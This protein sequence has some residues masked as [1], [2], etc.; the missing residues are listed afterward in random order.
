MPVARQFRVTIPSLSSAPTRLM[1]TFRR[2][3]A[4]LIATALLPTIG[5]ADE[6][7]ATTESES[8]WVTS[9]AALGE[10]GTPPATESESPVSIIAATWCYSTERH[11]NRARTKKLSS[12]GV[13][14]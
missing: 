5:F 8:V 1:N 6:E 13:R 11:P 4:G 14:P 3:A 10:T 7:A 9:I 12:V 2:F